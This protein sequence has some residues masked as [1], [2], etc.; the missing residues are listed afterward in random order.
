M[1][2]L[3]LPLAHD[4]GPRPG[5]VGFVP[6]TIAPPD[7]FLSPWQAMRAAMRNPIELWDR[8]LFTLPCR[9]IRRLGRKYLEIMDPALMHEVLVDKVDAF[10]KSDIQQRYIKPAL[11]NGL[12]AA[13]GASWRLQRP[14]AAPCFRAKALEQLIPVIGRVGESAASRLASND[15]QTVDVMPEM[16]RATFDVVAELVLG[17]EASGLDQH[18]LAQAVTDYVETIALADPI[19]VIGGA[20]WLGRIWPKRGRRGVAAMREQAMAALR[21]RRSSSAQHHDLLARLL[22]ARDRVTGKAMSDVDVRDNILTFMTAGNETTALTL[23]WA[24]YLIANDPLVQDRLAEE[25][26]EVLGDGPLLADNVGRLD[27]HLQVI[28]ETMRLYPPIAILQRRALCPVTIGGVALRKNDEVVCASYVMHRSALWWE[29]PATFDPDRF[30]PERSLGRHRLAHLPF[31]AG[32]H[33]C[34]GLPLAYMETVAILALLMRKIRVDQ[35]PTAEI[36]P[37]MRLTVRPKGGMP[38]KVRTR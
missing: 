20:G 12:L 2:A 33:I 11:G 26:A 15:G 37:I 28:K 29:R 17:R 27:F 8:E 1:T 16:M 10:V 34:I 32:K 21:R 9:E 22:S 6:Q 23:T 3:A 13:E 25:A 31:G 5:S 38:L 24:L 35:N 19:D 36:C 7:H 18:I 4:L 30:S 14:A